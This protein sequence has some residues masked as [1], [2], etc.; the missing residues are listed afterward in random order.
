LSRAWRFAKLRRMRSASR[1]LAALL[2]LLLLGPALADAQTAPIQYGYD[3]LGRLVT[4][5]DPNGNTAIYSYDLVGNLLSI[6]RV[7]ADGLPGPV[8][9]THF[10]PSRGKVGTAVSIFGKGFST[11]ASQNTV[12]FNGGAAPVTSAS[13]NR[14]VVTVPATAMTG[15]ISVTTPLGSATSAASFR[16]IGPLTLTPSSASLSAGGTLQFSVSGPGGYTPPV[17]WTVNGVPGA[18]AGVGTIS[19][20]GLYAAPAWLPQTITVTVKA[21]DHDDPTTSASAA[22]TVVATGTRLF[23]AA[24]QV[25]VRFQERLAI[26]AGV[27]ARVSASMTPPASQ[28]AVT[29]RVSAT[30]AGNPAATTT[31]RPVTASLAPVITAVAPATIARG[32]SNVEVTL[33]GA[34]LDADAGVVALLGQSADD[35]VTASIS[36][37][38]AD[39][40]Q[41]TLLVSVATGAATGARV[42]QITTP[43]GTSTAV[44][45]GADTLTVQ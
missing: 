3:E 7:D 11:T 13:P 44:D 42:L 21:A 23:S 34:G 43:T 15:P 28:R 5:V 18:N 38:T 10:T 41:A 22:V 35:D 8:A 19:T 32:A 45:T 27:V 6:Q 17:D 20:A 25:S 29:T 9:I 14:L 4:V 12:S 37:V 33:A 24:R 16:L 36:N 30:V 39:G 31:T 1:S 26:I 2:L 40:T